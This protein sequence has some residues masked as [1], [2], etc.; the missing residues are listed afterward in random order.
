MVTQSGPLG[1]KKTLFGSTS[2]YNIGR[3]LAGA[4]EECVWCPGFSGLGLNSSST[5]QGLQGGREEYHKALLKS[6]SFIYILF[7]KGLGASYLISFSS[8]HIFC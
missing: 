3:Q 2:L 4:P 8:L 1:Q 5:E 7:E 6:R